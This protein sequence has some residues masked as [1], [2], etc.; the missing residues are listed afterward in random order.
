MPSKQKGIQS[1]KLVL[2]VY[3]VYLYYKSNVLNQ[4]LRIA[5]FIIF[6]LNYLCHA[7]E[8]NLFEHS[9][10]VMELDNFSF[11]QINCVLPKPL[12]DS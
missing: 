10:Y 5:I 8:V 9:A 1:A 11:Y 7:L 2:T 12:N 4:L 3:R 6:V